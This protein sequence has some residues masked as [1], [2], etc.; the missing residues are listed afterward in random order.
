MSID[1]YLLKYSVV[2]CILLQYW[3]CVNH[4]TCVTLPQI[5][6]SFMCSS[7]NSFSVDSRVHPQGVLVAA[8]KMLKDKYG[9][10]HTTLQVETYQD[11]MS[12]CGPCQ[13]NDRQRRSPS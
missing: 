10:A 6:H 9:F 11:E 7:L 1:F 13:G 5:K 3:Y 4:W 2:D 8:G 12:S